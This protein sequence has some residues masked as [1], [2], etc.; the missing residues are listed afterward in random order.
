M[1]FHFIHSSYWT[2]VF[3]VTLMLI[4]VHLNC[5]DSLQVFLFSSWVRPLLGGVSVVITF[6]WP[7]QYIMTHIFHAKQNAFIQSIALSFNLTLISKWKIL[8]FLVEIFW[9]FVFYKICMM[10]WLFYWVLAHFFGKKHCL[11]IKWRYWTSHFWLVLAFVY[12]IPAL[13]YSVCSAALQKPIF[14]TNQLHQDFSMSI[15]IYIYSYQSCWNRRKHALP[16]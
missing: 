14:H 16:N 1:T 4:F 3:Q 11:N 2:K 9:Y 10:V 15:I 8:A 12:T 13:V 6:V 7:L 5:C